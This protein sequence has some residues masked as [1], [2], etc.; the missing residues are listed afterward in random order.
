MSDSAS[1]GL[2]CYGPRMYDLFTIFRVAEAVTNRYHPAGT[3]KSTLTAAAIDHIRTMQ[4]PNDGSVLLYY[5][6][7]FASAE[8]LRLTTVINCLVLQL[9]TALRPDQVPAQTQG[10]LENTYLESAIQ[11][12]DMTVLR[13]HLQKLCSLFTK[14]YIIIDGLDEFQLDDRDELLSVLKS[15]LDTG[16]GCDVRLFVASRPEIDISEGLKEFH[17]IVLSEKEAHRSSDMEHYIRAQL[18]EKTHGSRLDGNQALFDEV[19]AVL[20]RE[21]RGM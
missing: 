9:M 5:L 19:M 6:A 16:F 12:R 20:L 11:N 15:F 18:E 8:S 13:G 21:S 3:G 17:P 14:A 4:S 1:S 7:D 2:W 10:G